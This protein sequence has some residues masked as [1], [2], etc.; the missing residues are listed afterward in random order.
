[1]F[2]LPPTL[3]IKKGRIR[4]NTC[5]SVPHACSYYSH[6][7]GILPFCLMKGAINDIFIYTEKMRIM[8]VF[9]NDIVHETEFT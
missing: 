3:P 7:F 4:C 9:I 5:K 8:Q 2:E 1:M 6:F